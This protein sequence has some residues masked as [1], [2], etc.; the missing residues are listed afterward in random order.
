[1]LASKLEG[2]LLAQKLER[3][4]VNN[5]SIVALSF[6]E[7]KRIVDVLAAEP[8]ALAGLRLELEAQLKRHDSQTVRLE[9]SRRYREIE[10]RRA[11]GRERR[12]DRPA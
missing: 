4:L 5:N 1:V 12:L 3:A 6:E 7:R 10:D 9:Q 11:A 2:D 8:A